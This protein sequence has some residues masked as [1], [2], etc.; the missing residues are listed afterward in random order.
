MGG[1]RWRALVR[2]QHDRNMKW[3]Q[4][5]YPWVNGWLILPPAKGWRAVHEETGDQVGPA[6]NVL[7]LEQMIRAAQPLTLPGK[8]PV[9][10][11][12]DPLLAALQLVLGAVY[13]FVPVDAGFIA[14]RLCDNRALFAAT[15]E[16][17]HEQV[18]ADL[19]GDGRLR[20]AS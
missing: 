7:T 13:D 15:V 20:A 5:E 1:E 11:S 12:D 6:R 9:K 18:V 19:A 3:L 2:A 8:T 10:G 17:L 4:A 14:L 16:G